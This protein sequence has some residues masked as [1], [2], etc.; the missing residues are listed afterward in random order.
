MKRSRIDDERHWLP[1]RPSTDTGEFFGTD[2]GRLPA[3]SQPV[4]T[5]EDASEINNL[6]ER[7]Q[8]VLLWFASRGTRGGTADE[9]EEAFGLGHNSTSP[10]LSELLAMDL[11]T[12][13]TEKRKTRQGKSAFVCAISEAGSRALAKRSVA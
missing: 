12:R 2:L 5:S 6:A 3:G 1:S 13:T 7:R 4:E 10:R 9:L 8:R 11:V